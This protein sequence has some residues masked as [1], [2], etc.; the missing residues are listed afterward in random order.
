[1]M[2]LKQFI[3]GANVSRHKSR[4]RSF[5]ASERTTN[6]KEIGANLNEISN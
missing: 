2:L 6:I 1:M 5:M 4:L 3:Q